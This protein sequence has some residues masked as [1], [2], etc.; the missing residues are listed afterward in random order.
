MKRRWTAILFASLL[1][2]GACSN[3]SS[4]DEGSADADGTQNEEQTSE[5]S[6]EQAALM[7]IPD[8]VAT[9]NGTD[10]EKAEL[11]KQVE[12]ALGQYGQ[13]VEDAPNEQLNQLY[14]TGTITL[15]NK[16]VLLQASKDF[17]PTQEEIDTERAAQVEQAGGE[18]ELTKGIE[19]AGFSEEEFQ[20]LLQDNIQIRNYLDH[21]IGE[22]NVTEE[23]AKAFYDENKQA[24]SNA[25]TEGEGEG[26]EAEGQS[27]QMPPYE[28]VKEALIQQLKLQKTTEERQKVIADLKEKAEIEKFI[29]TGAQ[30]ENA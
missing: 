17:A 8:V 13:K 24:L 22:V 16:E 3:D 27:Q 14:Q 18:E 20:T 29:D 19:Q 4:N 9:V 23:E 5:D 21:Q 1:A 28:D 11:D 26:A 30:N 2:L 12:A 25:P 7:E 6:G 10:I 15:I